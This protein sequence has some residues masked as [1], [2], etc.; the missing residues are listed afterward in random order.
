MTRSEYNKMLSRLDD[1][2]QNKKN[3]VVGPV[4]SYEDRQIIVLLYNRFMHKF[5][6]YSVTP[7]YDDHCVMDGIRIKV[8]N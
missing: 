3:V 5:K 1:T 4:N 7:S 8:K 6:E 2:L